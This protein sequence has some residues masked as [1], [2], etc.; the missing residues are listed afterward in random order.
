MIQNCLKLK[1]ISAYIHPTWLHGKWANIYYRLIKRKNPSVLCITSKEKVHKTIVLKSSHRTHF[2]IKEHWLGKSEEW[3]RWKTSIFYIPILY[4]PPL[5]FSHRAR[6]ILNICLKPSYKKRNLRK[7]F[8]LHILS[9]D[10]Q[11]GL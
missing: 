10:V 9:L 7:T 6:H 3:G 1:H 11:W 2:K 5:S 8:S 4:Q